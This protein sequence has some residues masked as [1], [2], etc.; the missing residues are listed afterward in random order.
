L[1]AIPDSTRE[2]DGGGFHQV[3]FTPRGNALVVT[4]GSGDGPNAIHVFG[5]D[6]E[7]VPDDTPTVSPSS[8]IVPFGFIFDWRGHLLVSEA[9]SGA[10][11]SY[12]IEDDL[13]LSVINASVAN[14]NIATCWIIRTWRGDVITA[15]TGSDN[16]SLYD[17]NP[18][19]GTIQL[20]DS[21]AGF[22]DKPIDMATTKNGR[23][24][25]VLNAGNGTVGAFHITPFGGIED[26]GAVAGLPLQFAQGIA[27]R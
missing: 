9:G 21:A 5:I 19:D 7:G 14:N 13:T 4:Q 10:V 27:V 1:E 23:F 25:Y 22:G 24:L 15:N 20:K 26:L 11:S 18:V 16:L 8:G 3:A 2:L 6:E 17:V 12:A